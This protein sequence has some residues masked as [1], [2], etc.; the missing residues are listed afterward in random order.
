MVD[1]YSD[2]M[3][4]DNNAILRLN[5]IVV[6]V[7][8]SIF[9]LAAIIVL[10]TI[11]TIIQRIGAV[12]AFTIAFAFVVA[13]FTNVRRLEIFASTSAYSSLASTTVSYEA[14]MFFRFAAVE[15]VFIGVGL[16][17][18]SWVWQDTLNTH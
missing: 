10:Y 12:V 2:V 16:P 14:Y 6:S 8:S 5:K 11:K 13:A 3:V 15:V 9:P 7:L 4:Y 17:N 18:K 1:E